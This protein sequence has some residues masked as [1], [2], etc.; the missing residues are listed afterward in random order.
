MHSNINT[1]LA[2]TCRSDGARR[3]LLGGIAG[4]PPA[5]GVRLAPRRAL[6]EGRDDPRLQA[7]RPRYLGILSFGIYLGFGI[8][9]FGIFSTSTAPTALAQTQP[10]V[11]SVAPAA[12]APDWENQTVFRINKEEPHATKMPFPDAAGALTKKR[13]ESPWCRLLNGDW[14]FFWVPTPAQRP[15]GFEKP[16]YDDS[17][18]K[19]IPVP[20]SVEMLGYGTPI[21]TNITYP[22]KLAPPRVMDDPNP[23]YTTFTER[24]PV[25]SYRRTFTI[26]AD[27]KNR[28]IFITF[29]GVISAFYLYV[30]GHKV[31]YSQDSRTPAEFNIT[32]YLRADGAENLIAVEAYRYSDGSYLE[33]QD[34]WR[35]SGI[36]RDVYLWTSDNLDLR[37]FEVVGTLDD[38]YKTGLLN[39]KTWTKNY[40]A[41]ARASSF[42]IDATLTDAAGKTIASLTAT[43][44][45]GES[46]LGNAGVPPADEGRPDPRQDRGRGAGRT[47]S[48][49]GTPALPGK[50]EPEIMNSLSAS[51]APGEITP[52][53]AEI[54]TL[55]NLLLTLKNADG[56]PIA[57]YAI[58][59]GFQ[60]SE[61]KN[62]NLLVNGQP[63]LIKGVNR[64]D[65]DPVRGQYITEETMRAD[66]DAMK[67]HN[68]NTIRTSHYPNDPRFL[69]LVDEYGFYIISEANLETHGT[70]YGPESLAKDP[71]WGPAHLDRVRNMVEELKNHPCIIIWS[72]GNEAGEGVNFKT[73]ADWV[74]QRWPRR[75]VHY[76]QAKDKPYVDFFCPMYFQIDKLDAWC[77]KEEKLPLAQQRPM[78]QCE[79]NHTM[80]NSSGGLADYWQHYRAERLLQGGC[81]WDWR[82]QGIAR[83]ASAGSAG[84]SPAGSVGVS[85]AGSA[86]VSPADEGRPDP[87]PDQGQGAG[88]TLSAGGTPA[89][90]ATRGGSAAALAALDPARVAPDGSLRYFAYGG[91]YGDW[92]NDGSFSCDGV[93]AADL[94]EHPHSSEIFQQYRNI[95]VTPLDTAAAQPRVRVFN[96]NFFRAL[97]AQPYRWTLLE[98][99]D[100]IAT[101][102]ATLPAIAPQTTADIA[103]PIDAKTRAAAKPQCEYH[104]NI[105]FP[106]GADRPWAAADF[107]I[108]RDQ[109][110]LAWTKPA[111]S[112]VRSPESNSAALATTR[113]HGL[114][115]IAG[116]NF[117]ATID[118]RT[119]QL[120]SYKIAGKELLAAPL[121]M[122]FWRAPTDNDRGSKM[123]IV[124]A[125]WRT[126]GES[127]QVTY[128]S[129]SSTI[130]SSEA[131]GSTNRKSKIENSPTLAYDLAIPVGKTTAR[132]EYTISPDGKIAVAMRLRPDAGNDSGSGK[133]AAAKS[134]KN[135]KT[136]PATRAAKTA[137]G[138]ALDKLPDLPRVGMTYAI[139]PEYDTWTWFGRG[140]VENYCDRHTSAFVGRY[141]GPVTKLW[142]PYIEPGETGNRTDIRW[143]TFTDAAGRGLRVRA[144]GGQL[145]EMTAWP[146]D[147][148]DLELKHHPTDIPL[149]D[150]VTLQITHKQMGLGGEN[151]WGAWPLAKYRLPADKE[152]S[153]SYELEP[154]GF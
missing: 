93:M 17:S 121:R 79:Y 75:P 9:G 134:G 119:A 22:F 129:G 91:D 84:V 114:T 137:Q 34:M 133:T 104:L 6:G 130:V 136:A 132:I 10:P 59:T 23:A 81:D 52:Y 7:G 25:M 116:E 110:T 40:D 18:W 58:K 103:I 60:R 138:A 53:S 39:I 51:F 128:R 95:L 48:A 146:F 16:D 74:H 54:P 46:V 149:R 43:S 118:D 85:P 70:G 26:P 113:A 63:I 29:N 33:D 24:N 105:E 109:I 131:T 148:A 100:P 49:G 12:D 19:T 122:N 55:Y 99:G 92:P 20:S 71:S 42:S 145:L 101:G 27:W 111:E 37:D 44:A 13:M 50:N 36:F 124:C 73:C 144:T 151:S 61:V 11:F 77:R 94:S 153:Y 120:T 89:L 123:P 45:A 125:I 88:R 64:H 78:I 2:H 150:H 83:F 56:K 127:A 76:E 147:Q 143:S 47:P 115:T 28:Q 4:V 154:V 112:G 14:K 5:D 67:R 135:A 57:Y 32:P 140:P 87:R 107:I 80:G 126:A 41:A 86:G 31:G 69:E 30:N 98:D 96:E 82:D 141:S 102:T 152:Y 15:I 65:F 3:R 72:L 21:Y 106:Q 1:P 38:D 68:I 8:L 66:L 117:S 139:A 62:G 142:H 35:M 108:A 97:D 90:P